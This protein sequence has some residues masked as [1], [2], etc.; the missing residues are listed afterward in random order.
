MK[1]VRFRV[2]LVSLVVSADPVLAQENPSPPGQAAHHPPPAVALKNKDFTG[3]IGWFGVNEAA[4]QHD[5]AAADTIRFRTAYGGGGFGYYWSEHSKTEI[6][7]GATGTG[8]DYTNTYAGVANSPGS[9]QQIGRSF[10]TQRLTVSQ[11]Y[12]FRHNTGVHPS[13]AA[14]L[15]LDRITRRVETTTWRSTQPSVLTVVQGAPR[16]DFNV[17][18]FVSVG[19]KAYLSER[20]FVRSDARIGM[21]RRF[22]WRFGFGVDF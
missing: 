20:A 10:R 11:S 18:A 19:C 9:F 1:R 16:T 15:D 21:S 8:D 17:D 6:E 3:Y 5:S 14:G 22:L 4:I 2:F 13:V 7:I 12:Q